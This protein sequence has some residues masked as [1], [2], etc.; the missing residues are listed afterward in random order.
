L[1][2]LSIFLKLFFQAHSFFLKLIDEGE[3]DEEE[4]SDEDESVEDD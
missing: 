4:E 1:Q 3:S 2:D